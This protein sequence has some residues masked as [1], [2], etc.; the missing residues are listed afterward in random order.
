MEL[1]LYG[2]SQVQDV[3]GTFDYLHRH[4]WTAADRD[5]INLTADAIAL[6]ALQSSDCWVAT[7]LSYLSALH[8][9]YSYYV[10]GGACCKNHDVELNPDDT[11][12]D[13]QTKEQ[14]RE[15]S[16]D[17]RRATKEADWTQMRML[18][19]RMPSYQINSR[20]GRGEG[21]DED[22][23]KTALHYSVAINHLK[24]IR[25]LI[26]YGHSVMTPDGSGATPFQH[27][28]ETGKLKAVEILL[29]AEET[30]LG[31][32][33]ELTKARYVK[34]I[35]KQDAKGRSPFLAVVISGRKKLASWLMEKMGD[36]INYGLSDCKGNTL[37]LLAAKYGW[38][39]FME[40]FLEKLTDTSLVNN[41][42][43]EGETVL[44]WVLKYNAGGLM[45]NST[46]GILVNML[47]EKGA[48]AKLPCFMEAVPP[49]NL[50]SAA[51]NIEVYN[52]LIQEGADP[53]LE[54][55]AIEACKLLTELGM[56]PYLLDKQGNTPLHLASMRGQGQVVQF[57]LTQADDIVIALT[58]P[59]KQGLST[60]HLALKAGPE[61]EAQENS[62]KIINL[63]GDASIKNIMQKK[64]VMDTPL[65]LAIG[66]HQDQ[67]VKDLL[68]KGCDVNTGTHAGELPIAR[69]LSCVSA[70]T[71]DHDATIFDMLVQAG[72]DINKSSEAKHPLLAICKNPL[73]NFAERAVQ[74]LSSKGPLDWNKRDEKGYTPLMLAAF[75]DNA[76]LVKYLLEEVKVDPNDP[77]QCTRSSA[78]VVISKGGCCSS[79]VISP[80]VPGGQTPLMCAAKGASEGSIQILLNRGAKVDIEDDSGKTALGHAMHL[81]CIRTLSVA[82]ILIGM[83][84]QPVDCTDITGESWPHRAV[85]YGVPQFLKS[86]SDHGGSLEFLSTT[87]DDADDMPGAELSAE[88]KGDFMDSVPKRVETEVEEEDMEL[89]DDGQ[90]EDSE[91]EDPEDEPEE[92]S[93]PVA[94]GVDMSMFTSHYDG[95][96]TVMRRRWRKMGSLWWDRFFPSDEKEADMPPLELE[97]DLGY[98]DKYN[99]ND[100]GDD[101]YDEEDAMDEILDQREKA[102]RQLLP[103]GRLRPSKSRVLVTDDVSSD[104]ADL[105][106][107]GCRVDQDGSP[108]ASRRGSL[109]EFTS[110]L[111]R[112]TAFK[113]GGL[114]RKSDR[115]SFNAESSLLLHKIARPLEIVVDKNGRK[116]MKV[117]MTLED[118]AE[119]L[120]CGTPGEKL[121]ANEPYYQP[122]TRYE[123]MPKYMDEKKVPTS[124]V[125]DISD[126]DTLMSMLDSDSD[127]RSKGSVS[128]PGLWNVNARLKEYK[129]V[130]EQQTVSA[131]L[132]QRNIKWYLKSM[133]PQEFPLAQGK[134]AAFLK[135]CKKAEEAARQRRPLP[136][137]KKATHKKT[138]WFGGA[139]VPTRPE[140]NSTSPLV[141][142]VRL[143]RIS[144]VQV[145]LKH[146]PS[147]NIPDG[148]GVTPIQYALFLLLK[149]RHNK[150]VQQITDLIL[151]HL[152]FTSSHIVASMYML[153]RTDFPTLSSSPYIQ[154]VQQITDTILSH[155][156]FASSRAM[157]SMYLLPRAEKALANARKAGTQLKDLAN[158]KEKVLAL[159]NFQPVNHPNFM[160][161]VVLATLLNDMCAGNLNDSYV[162]LPDIPTYL[163]GQWEKMAGNCRSKVLPLH[164]GVMQKKLETVRLMLD[165]GADPNTFGVEYSGNLEKDIERRRSLFREKRQ[166]VKDQ[167]E[168]GASAIP[169]ARLWTNPAPGMLNMLPGI[170]HFVMSIEIPGI[171]RPQPWVSPLHLS[172]RF[173]QASITYLLIKR[174][175]LPNGGGAAVYAKKSPLEEALSYAR[176]NC[177][178]Y[179]TLADRHNFKKVMGLACWETSEAG[180]VESQ[181]LAL[182]DMKQ[183]IQDKAEK[184]MRSNPKKY[185]EMSAEGV[186]T[187]SFFVPGSLG[188]FSYMGLRD[189]APPPMNDVCKA[190][191]VMNAIKDLSD[192]FDPVSMSIKAV[193]LAAK[194]LIIILMKMIKRPIAHW[195][196][197]LNTAHHLDMTSDPKDYKKYTLRLDSQF[198]QQYMNTSLEF[199]LPAYFMPVLRKHIAVVGG[200]HP[201][202]GRNM[203]HDS[204]KKGAAELYQGYIMSQV[205]S[206]KE[207]LV[208]ACY[209]SSRSK[210]ENDASKPSPELAGQELQVWAQ[211]TAANIKFECTNRSKAES[212][213]SK[214]SPDLAGHEFQ[215]WARKTAATIKANADSKYS[216]LEAD[217]ARGGELSSAAKS[218][219]RL[220]A[221]SQ[222]FA[223]WRKQAAKTLID[224]EPKFQAM[225]KKVNAG[226]LPK[227]YVDHPGKP[228]SSP[229]ETMDMIA[230]SV[231]SFN[232]SGEAP[233][234]FSGL[235]ASNDFLGQLADETKGFLETISPKFDME[236][237]EEK[238]RSP[239]D[240]TVA[241]SVK[242]LQIAY[243]EVKSREGQ[244]ILAERMVNYAAGAEEF[245]AK[246]LANIRLMVEQKR[247]MMTKK[248]EALS[249]GN[250][251]LALLDEDAPW[252]CPSHAT[253]VQTGRSVARSVLG[254]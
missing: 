37:P 82:N 172:C 209:V 71:Y 80:G 36:D 227:W 253:K 65:M 86:W 70:L 7:A 196:P 57:L 180:A 68:E 78:P 251:D 62:K 154:V 74:V 147:I 49:I 247:Q 210:A 183:K 1:G 134:W 248:V 126:P 94:E 164:V 224:L 156:P 239:E 45:D 120:V 63:L 137:G 39:D 245:Q 116:V 79:A 40:M 141:L 102:M 189:V 59:N 158:F 173:G 73:S 6:T 22:V 16:R 163:Q 160:D 145:L 90:G 194:F 174:G 14:M 115:E 222:A 185:G 244:A 48:M 93:G 81:D 186:M 208:R 138:S 64:K 119:A 140:L 42:N 72:A 193:C 157:A 10:P 60:Y 127:P 202:S 132:R 231:A 206:Q 88:E 133:S 56:K 96:T 165:M 218:S 254:P 235:D 146:S 236:Q 240:L 223:E 23:G 143:G 207:R 153:P 21:T 139:D 122:A 200:D 19:R 99:C 113:M 104:G 105:E 31:H 242:A 54:K 32:W 77:E 114:R 87:A 84:A 44:G 97:D 121:W 5:A 182:T 232:P 217:R 181:M 15:D 135:K 129:I 85:R 103:Q 243:I 12:K 149:D 26:R 228:D 52:I 76:W 24:G 34:L 167:I 169:Y 187:M 46:T 144:C 192:F 91:A 33:D 159:K 118:R 175:A 47:L 128:A 20:V 204:M 151:S 136:L 89:E 110:K 130:K 252:F 108:D 238:K 212:D 83:G 250:L 150:V 216:T 142:A 198:N 100:E 92:V 8:S 43:N 9:S 191:V 66:G 58:T 230:S 3:L 111:L 176:S 148:F 179:N 215:G 219:L 95:P 161:P 226:M 101:I 123:G 190:K 155:L 106:G 27:A 112:D 124:V 25:K 75:H 2:T 4:L 229:E 17:L 177:Q 107:A 67:I 184:M 221:D 168:A 51:N 18:T 29:G 197:A 11:P 246:S 234:D 225:A 109:T 53:V 205:Q 211:E 41:R 214:P 38:F 213:A 30:Q 241:D 117:N 28:V 178:S 170:K 201:S 61:E 199:F 166:V 195:D 188:D 249:S 171:T 13:P 98:E 237:L 50:A 125:V 35:N 233:K 69:N 220:K 55:G 203:S 131:D 162:A 152:P